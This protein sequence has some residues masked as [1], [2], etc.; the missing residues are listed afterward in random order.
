MTGLDEP[1]L[2]ISGAVGIVWQIT[3]EIVLKRAFADDDEGIKNEYRIY[4]LLESMPSYCPNLGRSFYRIPS[5]NFLQY[6]SNGNLEER[7]RQ[8][9]TR[10]IQPTTDR[11]DSCTVT[12]G[13]QNVVLD[14]DDHLKLIDF[15][16]TT[17]TGSH[18]DGCPPPYARVLGDEAAADRGRFG[19]H[20]PHTEQFAI[21]SIYYYMSRGYEP[22]DDEWFG[23]HHGRMVVQLLQERKFP[24]LKEDDA[25]DTIIHKCWQGEFP[26]VRSLKLDLIRLARDQGLDVAMAAAM[27]KDEYEARHREC[28]ELVNLGVLDKAS[29]GVLRE[30]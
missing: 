30:T 3:N 24:V 22:Y 10:D 13:Q 15:D 8:H 18:F 23:K 9:Q 29:R 7:L 2:L 6:C 4:D 12:C 25:M 11:L 17:E 27:P 5:A 14:S 16:N 20:G 26:L 1:K 28:R 19:Y 21:G